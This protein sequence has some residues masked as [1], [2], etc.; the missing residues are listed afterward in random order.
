MKKILP[1]GC[2]NAIDKDTDRQVGWV[3]SARQHGLDPDKLKVVTWHCGMTPDDAVAYFYV[4]M[5]DPPNYLVPRDS[6]YS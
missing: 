1:L 5:S 6:I 3:T 4:R 2:C